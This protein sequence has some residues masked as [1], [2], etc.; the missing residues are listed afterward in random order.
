MAERPTHWTVPAIRAKADALERRGPGRINLAAET[1]SLLVAALRHL[2][3]E[4]MVERKG[5]YR[6]EV[7]DASGDHIVEHIGSLSNHAAARAAFAAACEARPGHEVTLRQGARIV[8]RRAGPR[9][10]PAA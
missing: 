5:S 6:V 8:D 7:W 4:G 10:G 1:I 9:D 2:A 3:T